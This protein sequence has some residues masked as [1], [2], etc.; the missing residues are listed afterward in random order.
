MIC[1]ESPKKTAA[2]GIISGW[3]LRQMIARGECPGI[4]TGSHFKVNVNA[5][6]EKLEA[7]SRAGKKGVKNG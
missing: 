7:E 4:Y 2:R 5:L 3:H 6:V 1:F